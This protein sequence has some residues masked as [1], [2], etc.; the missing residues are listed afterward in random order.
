MHHSVEHRFGQDVPPV[1][2][3]IRLRIPQPLHALV[4]EP[5]PP[6]RLPRLRVRRVVH[7]FLTNNG[8]AMGQYGTIKKLARMSVIM[9]RLGDVPGLEHVCENLRD[10]PH[11]QATGYAPFLHAQTQRMRAPRHPPH[12]LA[13]AL[14]HT[15]SVQLDVESAGPAR[16]VKPEVQPSP[17]DRITV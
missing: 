9:E 14:Q 11:R 1:G 13:R 15:F 5:D 17:P 12:G 16:A 10:R 4:A 7:T 8:V 6:L 3:Q 2:D